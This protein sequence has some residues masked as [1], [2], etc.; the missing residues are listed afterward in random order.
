[1][2]I[3]RNIIESLPYGVVY[4]DKQ[5]KVIELNKKII[6]S[7]GDLRGKVLFETESKL[8]KPEIIA[9]LDEAIEK[10]CESS[11]IVTN[12]IVNHKTTIINISIS[13][14]KQ[15]DEIVGALMLVSENNEYNQWQR[16]FNLLFESVP[17]YIS[18]VDPSLKIVRASQ[19]FRYTFGRNHS[20]FYTEPGKKKNDYQD[21]PTILCFSDN[22][23]HTDTVISNT[24]NGE[25]VH[26][27]VT[28]VPFLVKDNKTQLVMEIMLDITELNQLQEQLNL[29]HDFYSDLLDNS[30]DGII[31]IDT[32]GRV[33]IFNSTLKDILLW[34]V[35]RKPTINKIQELLPKEFFDEADIDGI[36][37]QDKDCV[38]KSTVGDK[39]PVRLNAFEIRDKKKSVGRVGF[40]QDLRNVKQLEKQKKDAERDALITTF[41]SVGKS[42]FSVFA[43]QDDIAKRFEKIIYS[44]RN[45]DFKIKS[46]DNLKFHYDVLNKMILDFIKVASGFES[47][48]IELNL[49]QFIES[50]VREFRGL[51]DFYGIRLK[52]DYLLR[53]GISLYDEYI[54]RT[55]T[56][57]LLINSIDSAKDVPVGGEVVFHAEDY[58]GKPIILV[59]DN[60]ADISKLL[61]SKKRFFKDKQE[62]GVGFR[63]LQFLAEKVEGK[64]EIVTDNL[65][66][67]IY[68]F[69]F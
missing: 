54:Y 8:S 11:L 41:N 65:Q 20:I 42:I 21:N 33:Q 24:I 3:E 49:K 23:E 15:N 62:I 1:M 22:E 35:I 30:A 44:D 29:T 16:D 32:K 31:A 46:W 56:N 60:G 36:I 68:K 14:V 38:L 27:I 69:E 59:S 7:F 67:N 6:S 55:I 51:A 19:K 34:N 4:V 25:K 52:E 18:I 66:G 13:P 47:N 57:I 43:Y 12:S 2:S 53:P 39:I 64:F 17:S 28:S 45:I 63:T 40:F 10:G 48:P 9:R 37:L 26:L 5:Q 50:T 58:L 61:D